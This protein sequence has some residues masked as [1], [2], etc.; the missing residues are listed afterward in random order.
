MLHES[1]FNSLSAM[2]RLLLT[3]ALLITLLLGSCANP[4]QTVIDATLSGDPERIARAVLEDQLQRQ[5]IPTDIEGLP[6][7]IAAVSK[8]LV[9]V[10]GE[11]EPEVASEHRYVKYSNAFEARAIVDFDEGWLQ[12]ETIA[13]EDPLGKLRQA[14]INTLLTTRDMSIE[15]IFTDATPPV[16]GE[17]FLLGQVLDTEGQAIRWQWRAERFADH[18]IKE[19]LRRTQQN[20][21][22]LRSV[23]VSLVDDH[24]HLRELEYANYVLAASRRYGVAPSLIYAVIEVESAF[25]PYAVSLANAYGL[26]QVVPSSAGR[27]V[28][29]RIK[30]QGG[31]PTKQQLFNADF[32][33]DIGSAYLHLLSDSYLS[34]INNSSSRQFTTVSAYNGGAGS[35]LRTFS[36]NNTTALRRINE[37]S[38][39]EVYEQLTKKH[40]FAE[41]RRYLEKVRAAERK[42]L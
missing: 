34:G 32:N 1:M 41:T 3:P 26:M 39:G 40:P 22:E 20:G 13:T 9:D 31:E 25:N 12:V 6:E 21:K 30:K 19:Q 29:E 17:P 4:S 23:R 27:D 37:M 11:K 35:A 15:D 14:I 38:S 24:L 2:K 36:P 8:I 18:L 5:G 42:Y 28:Y 7:L 16:D 33:I 10:W